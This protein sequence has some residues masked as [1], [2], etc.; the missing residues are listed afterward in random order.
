MVCA[1]LM[2]DIQEMPVL[3]SFLAA[4]VGCWQKKKERKQQHAN[5]SIFFHSFT[6]VSWL[7]FHMYTDALS[8]G[9]GCINLFARLPTCLSLGYR[10]GVIHACIHACFLVCVW[11][12]HLDTCVQFTQIAT[13]HA[14]CISAHDQLSLSSN[15]RLSHPWKR[16][17]SNHQYYHPTSKRTFQSQ[18]R[19]KSPCIPYLPA[20]K[21]TLI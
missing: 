5:I 18:H 2:S 12:A 17:N 3:C 19:S 8:N 1:N 6:Y 13:Q 14:S 11:F 10:L 16:I 15:L 9:S 21:R 20:Q 7:E 4:I